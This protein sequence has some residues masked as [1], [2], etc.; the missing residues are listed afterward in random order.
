MI[1]DP[2]WLITMIIVGSMD[3]MMIYLASRAAV[4]DSFAIQKIEF[5]NHFSFSKIKKRSRFSHKIS[6]LELIL[7][8]FYATIIALSAPI[9]DVDLALR[10]LI[11]ICL[12]MFAKLF[13]QEKLYACITI[14]IIFFL[15]T[16][17]IQTFLLP[18]FI[19][20]TLSLPSQFI[21]IQTAAFIGII[22]LT[23]GFKMGKLGTFNLVN[24][25]FSLNQ[26]N[27]V[28]KII[29]LI[30]FIFALVFFAIMNF[31]INVIVTQTLLFIPLIIFPFY[32]IFSILN[33]AREKVN[34]AARKVHDY[35]QKLYGLHTSLQ[36]LAGDNEEIIRESS[37]ILQLID[38]DITVECITDYT[39]DMAIFKLLDDKAEELKSKG[40]FV[41]FYPNFKGKE[42]HQIVSFADTI[43]M[44]LSLVN[45][46]I[47][48]GNHQ[49]PIFV[50]ILID[51][52]NLQIV[53]ANACPPKNDVEIE[54]MFIDGY[55]TVP[56]IGR[57][58]GLSNLKSDLK[59]YEKD[60]FISGIL[61]DSFYN[62]RKST[63]YLMVVVYVMK[64]SIELNVDELKKELLS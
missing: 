6:S 37:E 34:E 22:M 36:L 57:G 25:V 50:N 28:F 32:G 49:F 43:S 33:E 40:I 38:K 48:H 14:Y 3:V 15:F 53:V 11:M 44:M 62:S 1:Q 30:L 2:I 64:S 52:D 59:R 19:V 41:T 55:S 17:T 10:L 9:F 45:N 24:R 4:N 13:S 20:Y 26:Q 23:H 61:V 42:N 27:L 58:Y 7:G 21:L 5:E 18:L 16:S 56:E 8:T 35:N 29:T 60:D 39:R 51:S 31:D 12:I 47:D 54:K 46:S 63:D